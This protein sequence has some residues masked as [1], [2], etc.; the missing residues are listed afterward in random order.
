MTD[1]IQN[2]YTWIKVKQFK[3]EDY[4]TLE[5]KYE[6]LKVHHQKETEFLIKKVRQ[7]DKEESESPCQNFIM[8]LFDVTRLCQRC[9]DSKTGKCSVISNVKDVAKRLQEAADALIFDTD[10][11]DAINAVDALDSLNSLNVLEKEQA[12][13]LIEKLKVSLRSIRN[14]NKMDNGKKT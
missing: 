5:E 10:I 7:L 9:K 6:A 3:E 2:G 13:T 12:D 8:S 1:A 11:N 14:R 4:P